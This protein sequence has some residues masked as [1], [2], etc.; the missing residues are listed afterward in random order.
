MSRHRTTRRKSPIRVF[1][2]DDHPVLMGGLR[3]LIDRQD[4]LRV[5]GQA[6]D[7]RTAVRHVTTLRPDVVV[8]DLLMPG[9]DGISA[10]TRIRSTCPDVEVLALTGQ[11]QLAC[12]SLMLA[13]GAA[14]ICYKQ[15]PPSDLL[16][17]IRTIAAGGAYLDRTVPRAGSTV[18]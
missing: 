8:M 12:A 16:D 3:A 4:D 10:T 11:R 7:G 5:V 1:L 9:L 18:C 6:A 13:A 2:V 14:G 15:S 17:A